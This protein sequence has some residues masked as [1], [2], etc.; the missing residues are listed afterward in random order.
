V[1]RSLIFNVVEMLRSPTGESFFEE[2]MRLE[3]EIDVL[4]AF[5][6]T[7]T[8]F[9]R[10]SDA[11]EILALV[12][13]EQRKSLKTIRQQEDAAFFENKL[14][15]AIDPH[16]ETTLE[17]RIVEAQQER[18]N[19]NK[20]VAELKGTLDALIASTTNLAS[21]AS[22]LEG[23]FSYLGN[24]DPYEVQKL[25][26]KK[27]Q[28]LRVREKLIANIGILNRDNDWKRAPSPQGQHCTELKRRIEELEKQIHQR[29]MVID[30]HRVLVST[31]PHV[32]PKKKRVV[33]YE[34]EVR[35]I[36]KKPR[37]PKVAQKPLDVAHEP[38]QSADQRW[39]HGPSACGPGKTEKVP[40]PPKKMRGPPPPGRGSNVGQ[41]PKETQKLKPEENEYSA[42]FESIESGHTTPRHSRQSS[43]SYSSAASADT[44]RLASPVAASKGIPKSQ[45]QHI[46]DKALAVAQENGDDYDDDFEEAEHEPPTFLTGFDLPRHEKSSAQPQNPS[47]L[48]DM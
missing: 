8:M 12:E 47:W 25:R 2:N 34:E 43:S 46:V 26:R 45:V 14:I 16:F 48:S 11:S 33:T 1:Y 36:P 30:S 44:A 41:K 23:K 6:K 7:W 42:D 5:A 40:E 18:L 21:V 9:R 31:A 38:V 27:E 37:V 39:T 3:K 20:A 24:V 35:K 22:E 32:S 19:H 29:E 13:E 15:E 28:N 10:L 4:S 17:K